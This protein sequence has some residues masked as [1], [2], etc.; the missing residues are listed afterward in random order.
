MVQH[1]TKQEYPN[2]VGG[3]LASAVFLFFGYLCIAAPEAMLSAPDWDAL[4]DKVW[5]GRT[6]GI[7]FLGGALVVHATTFWKPKG[8]P[9]ID[10]CLQLLGCSVIAVAMACIIWTLIA[11]GGFPFL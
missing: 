7:M 2:M 10:K 1:P 9:T 6:V 4:S 3:L 5:F 8:Y 11:D